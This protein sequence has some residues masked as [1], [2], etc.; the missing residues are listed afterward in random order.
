MSNLNTITLTDKNL[1]F[2]LEHSGLIKTLANNQGIYL[3]DVAN[4]EFVASK[5]MFAQS[6]NK[7]EDWKLFVELASNPNTYS[8]SKGRQELISNINYDS[9]NG[10]TPRQAAEMLDY[11]MFNTPRAP[12]A[13]IRM[14]EIPEAEAPA[15]PEQAPAQPEAQKEVPE[16]AP[17]QPEAPKQEL[18]ITPIPQKSKGGKTQRQK[19]KRTSA[20]RQTRS[21][22]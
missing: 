17:A 8:L 13:N 3:K 14:I 22:R 15:V 10:Y 2:W 4:T 18:L 7:E 12:N 11:L 16:Q 20:K 1:E 19:Q 6:S 5:D 21:K 9:S